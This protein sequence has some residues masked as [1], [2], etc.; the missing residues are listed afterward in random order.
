ML[1]LVFVELGVLSLNIFSLGLSPDSVRILFICNLTIST[2]AA[3]AANLL[4]SFFSFCKI[5]LTIPET[6]LSERPLNFSTRASLILAILG[7]NDIE[8]V[9]LLLSKLAI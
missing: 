1:V 6:S 3:S 5:F 9:F 7:D 4:T 8:S 2:R